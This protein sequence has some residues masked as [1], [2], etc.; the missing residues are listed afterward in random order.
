MK[1]I[2]LLFATIFLFV[3]CGSYMTEIWINEDTSGKTKISIDAG[4][5]IDMFGMAMQEMDEDK[6]DGDDKIKFNNSDSFFGEGKIDSTI[7]MYDMAPDSVKQKMANPELLKNM[8]MEMKGDADKREMIVSMTMHYDSPE[9][10]GDIFS[11]LSAMQEGGAQMGGV[12]NQ[13]DMKNMFDNQ[14]VDY[15]NGIVRVKMQNSL[16]QLEEEGLYDEEMKMALDS[17]KLMMD[18]LGLSEDSADLDLGELAFLKDMLDA[19][20][21]SVYHLPGKVQ[22]TN[23]RA[24]IIDG[25][26]VTFIDNI[27]DTLL[28]GDKVRAADRII[29]YTVK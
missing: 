6:E 4:E 16:E 28:N 10:L 7:V 15:K 3:G 24:A 14:A 19:E 12:M 26:T 13:D 29:K 18:E 21:K 23:D 22:F 20:L 27:W 11:Q 8:I 9:E 2:T 5:M 25:K 1:R 17:L